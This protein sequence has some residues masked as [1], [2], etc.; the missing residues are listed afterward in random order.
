[1]ERTMRKQAITSVGLFLICALTSGA[2][3]AKDVPLDKVLGA[4]PKALDPDQLAAAKSIMQ[5]EKVYFGCKDTIASCLA[6]EKESMTAR[7]L[8]GM[9]VRKVKAGHDAAA[10]HDMIEKRGLSMHPIK[11][12]EVS[13]DK[14]PSTGSDSPTV[15]VAAF[16]DFQCP[17]CKAIL[18]RLEKISG[19]LAGVRLYFKHFPVKKHKDAP[20]A[21]VASL[22][23]HGQGKFWP[24]HD[25]CY[26]DPDH[27]EKDDLVAKAKQAG[28]E[29]LARFEK[30]LGSKDLMKAVESD[31]IEGL[32]LGVKG[33]PTIYIDGKLYLGETSYEDLVDVLSEEIDLAAGKK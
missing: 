15:E 8:A 16:S 17:F 23:A 2:A 32:K 27:L 11:T 29:D 13:I 21:A 31:K 14:A 20:L 7:R 1:M 6:G 4:D 33:T 26:E 19:K 24:F 28:V 22:A 3:G 18:P 12:Y 25:L 5:A 9:V 30:D 10:I